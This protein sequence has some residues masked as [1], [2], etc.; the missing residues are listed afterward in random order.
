[1]KITD[2]L[3]GEHGVFYAQ[4]Q[5]INDSLSS[6]NLSIIQSLGAML[7]AA[8]V[9]HAQIENEILFPALEEKIGESGPTQVMRMEHAEIE[10][11]LRELKDL[12][13][14]HDEIEGALAKLPE[15]DKVDFARR[16]VQDILYTAR[17]HFAKEENVLFPMAEQMLDER[18]Q[19]LLGLEWAKRR[20]VVLT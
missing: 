11:R 12:K 19:E 1:M 10:A 6:A 20:G 8:L 7:A 16:T 15:I 17:E 2:A 5:F 4:F 13:G 3:K 18:T 9:P 14:A